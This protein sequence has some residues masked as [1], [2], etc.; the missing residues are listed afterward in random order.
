MILQEKILFNKEECQ[1][2]LENIEEWHDNIISVRLESKLTDKGGVMKSFKIE[3]NNSNSWIKDRVINWANSLDD[4]LYKINNNNNLTAGYRKYTKGD[5]FIKHDDHIY[6]GDK[7]LYTIGIMLHK[8]ENLIGGDLKMYI[9][10]S[11][12]NIDFNLGKV[13]I[14]DSNIPH[15]VDLIQMGERITLIFFIVESDIIKN[16]NHII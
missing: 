8:S 3:W 6:N 4:I 10:D 13:Y 16:T 5:Y 12:I 7:R 15:S 1:S 14:F 11:V 9:D 2:I